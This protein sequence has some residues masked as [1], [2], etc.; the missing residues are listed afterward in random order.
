MFYGTN[1]TSNGNEQKGKLIKQDFSLSWSR[2]KL[3]FS[4]MNLSYYSVIHLQAHYSVTSVNCSV[5]TGQLIRKTYAF[6]S[7][8]KSGADSF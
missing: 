7:V 3:H 2:T 4:L 5:S 6:V 8:K 1:T